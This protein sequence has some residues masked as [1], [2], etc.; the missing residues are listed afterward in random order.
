MEDFSSV[1]CTR[2]LIHGDLHDA[3]Q[4]YLTFRC[5]V[6]EVVSDMSLVDFIENNVELRG[7]V[8]C[9]WPA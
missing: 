7:E 2:E 5:Q 9:W 1:E 8:S 4:C 6:C 3:R